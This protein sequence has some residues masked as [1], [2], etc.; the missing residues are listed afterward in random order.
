MHFIY[1]LCTDC[2]KMAIE[3]Y[4]KPYF[5][6]GCKLLLLGKYITDP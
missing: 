2:F 1:F 6:P 5:L 3:A 4:R